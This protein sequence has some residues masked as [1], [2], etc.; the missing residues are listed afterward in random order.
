[1]ANSYLVP[2]WPWFVK[3]Q[4]L[5]FGMQ[6]VRRADIQTFQPLSV[7]WGRDANR[8]YCAGSEMRGAD[9]RTF[10]VLNPLYALDARH[11]YTINGP[12]PA[13]DVSTFTAVGATDHAFSTTNGYA[14][15]A[16]FVF[17]TIVEG[18]AC[19][20]KGADP[21]SFTSRGHGFGSDKLAVYF[22]RKK[23]AGADTNTWQ[24]IRGPHSHS[25]E[26]GYILE[27]RIRG[28]NGKCLE[29]LPILTTEYWS[30]DDK[31]YYHL[32]RASDPQAY[33]E[34]FRRC[35]IFLGKVS[36]VS[37]TWNRTEQLD[38]THADSWAIAQHAWIF[39]G[40]K[41]WIQKPDLEVAD[42]PRLG[43]P[44]KFGE[45]LHLSLLASRSWMEEDRI[46]IFTPVQDYQRVEERLVLSSTMVWWEYSALDQ[47]DSIRKTIA[48]ANSS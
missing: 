46:W 28:A 26:K 43:E 7:F 37:L 23:L 47:L 32:D 5:F 2:G 6:E 48:D 36:K 1:M 16:R 24:H 12:I 30:R 41:E 9:V 8:V 44:F 18:K 38:P 45:G 29:S 4:R 22:E 27:K 3:E 20:I 39:V 21:A 35:F 25:G 19:V 42:A 40:C 34:V 33:F 14:K 11:A 10:R 17:H 15:D 31:D 13:A